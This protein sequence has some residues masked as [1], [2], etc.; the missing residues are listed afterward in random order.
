MK[1]LQ[2]WSKAKQVPEF[3][4]FV[5]YKKIV[6]LV[7][8]AILFLLFYYSGPDPQENECHVLIT[9]HFKSHRVF[10]HKHV[11]F[12]RRKRRR[13][14]L[15]TWFSFVMERKHSHGYKSD[16]PLLLVSR[17][18]C[19]CLVI[20]EILQ[21]EMFKWQKVLKKTLLPEVLDH[22]LHPFSEDRIGSYGISGRWLPSLAFKISFHNFS[23]Q[24]VGSVV[25]AVGKVLIFSQCLT[26]NFHFYS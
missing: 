21:K 24:T 15:T 18:P 25:L 2:I 6:Y 3:C 16:S 8:P 4:L 7:F 12:C 20:Q 22:L 13:D 11:H 19:W 1:H 9:Q 17:I 14:T 5:L 10:S 26:Q 23:A